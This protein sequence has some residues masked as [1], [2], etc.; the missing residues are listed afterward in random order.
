MMNGDDILSLYES[1][2]SLSGDMLAAAQAG[3]W[4]QLVELETRCA[5]QVQIL[6]AG[7]SA[8]PLN[9]ERRAHKVAMIRKILADDREIRDLTSPWMAKLGAMLQSS[10]A[11]RRLANAYGSQAF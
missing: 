2:S 7:E 9:A 10:G 11:E 3:E 6:R 5:S 8:T 4:D 1:V